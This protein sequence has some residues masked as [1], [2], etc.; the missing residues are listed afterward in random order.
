M[1]KHYSLNSKTVAEEGAM[2]DC[3]GGAASAA[4]S[5]L[6]LSRLDR[7]NWTILTAVG[8]KV[9]IKHSMLHLR[10]VR[11]RLLF[12]GEV[13]GDFGR[14]HLYLTTTQCS[15]GFGMKYMTVHSTSPCTLSEPFQSSQL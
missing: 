3:K 15:L 7:N 4:P 8:T 2:R 12:R 5:A 6:L 10:G 13:G 1:P 14:P 9:H 11:G